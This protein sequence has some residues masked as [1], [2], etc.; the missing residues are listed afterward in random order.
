MID[1]TGRDGAGEEARGD[2][3][4]FSARH[5]AGQGVRNWTALM[6]LPWALAWAVQAEMAAEALRA[7]R[8]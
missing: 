1:G 6:T 3:F 8:D 2:P 7:L 5:P 4:G